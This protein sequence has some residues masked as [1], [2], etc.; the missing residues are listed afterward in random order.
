MD[1]LTDLEIDEYVIYAG[2]GYKTQWKDFSQPYYLQVPDIILNQYRY[3]INWES[4]ATIQRFP[5]DL[6]YT[7]T[8]SGPYLDAAFQAVE[9]MAGLAIISTL[10]IDYGATE[11][12]TYIISLG[13]IVVYSLDLNAAR[14][15]AIGYWMHEN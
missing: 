11:A 7:V 4:A 15:K 6:L 9:G 14:W 3:V 5:A 13:G 10:L 12:L 2:G 1:H 8:R